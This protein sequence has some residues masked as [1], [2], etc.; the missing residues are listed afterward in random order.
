MGVGIVVFALLLSAVAAQDTTCGVSIGWDD[1]RVLTAVGLATSATFV[2]A[3]WAFA[4]ATAD[5]ARIARAR[6]EAAQL[7]I[8]AVLAVFFVLIVQAICSPV[9]PSFF[10]LPGADGLESAR[11]YVSTVRGDT[12][13]GYGLIVWGTAIVSLAESL[14]IDLLG[15]WARGATRI[16]LDALGNSL[17]LL[18][19]LMLTAVIVMT[20][21]TVFLDYFEQFALTFLLPAGVAFRAIWPFRRWGGA[22][23]GIGIALVVVF[24]FLL[25]LN[26]LL[27]K[28]LRGALQL[29][30]IACNANEECWSKVCDAATRR[31]VGPL[32]ND[33]PCTHWWQCASLRCEGGRCIESVGYG[34]GCDRSTQCALGY[35]CHYNFCVAANKVGEVCTED[36][37]CTTHFCNETT[38]AVPRE[39]GAVCSRDADCASRWCRLGRCAPTIMTEG[40]LKLAKVLSAAAGA[41]M[42]ERVRWPWPAGVIQSLLIIP[43][44]V[45]FIVGILLPAINFYLVARA[46]AAL[47]AFFG[48]EI[49]IGDVLRLL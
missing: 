20:A 8:T 24:P 13:R 39:V 38:C 35:M 37:D 17:A 1:W 4:H 12:L 22:M 44:V 33:A 49:E 10:G 6:H 30:E 28:E 3:Y 2:A 43:A 14:E 46:A 15:Y 5:S 41:N 23:V 47:S 31:C 45:T 19:S 36:R 34:G 11:T 25:N 18:H 16:V 29:P 7:F 26:A 27:T 32:A 48:A 21:H 42:I 9:I 40:D